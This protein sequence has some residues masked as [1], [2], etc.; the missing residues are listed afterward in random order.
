M[1]RGARKPEFYEDPT[2]SLG[3]L[4][5]LTFRAFGRALQKRLAA[6]GV[7]IGQWRFLRVLWVEDGLTQRELSRRVGLREPTTVTALKGLEK[8]ALVVRE[9]SEEDRRRVH[10]HLTPKARRLR[11]QL[12][13]HVAEVNRIALKGMSEDELQTVKRLLLKAI[14]N[15][16]EHNDDTIDLPDETP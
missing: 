4:A 8:A 14:A 15:L 10:V 9:Q 12:M 13:P 16:A 7:T 3:Y 5:R 1:A 6:K 11:K 2:N